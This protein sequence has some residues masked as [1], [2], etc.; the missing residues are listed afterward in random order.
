MTL[1][2]LFEE[3]N[4]ELNLMETTVHEVIALSKAISGRQVTNL[5]KTAASSYLAQFYTGIE[6]ILKRICKFYN[7]KLPKTDTWHIDMFNSFCSPPQKPLPALFDESLKT[8]LT[9]F[10][11]FR[12]V[13][14]HGYGFLMGWER[15]IVGIDR[16][17]DIFLRFK[18]RVFSNWL[19]LK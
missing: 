5:E 13:V 15:L 9:G 14:H 8:D 16:V 6:N 19:E 10:R 4:I 3:I 1:E 2:E 11:K 12:H 17:E 7:M 18:A